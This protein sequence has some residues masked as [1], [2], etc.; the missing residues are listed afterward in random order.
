MTTSPIQS[1]DLFVIERD[2]VVYK[3]SAEDLG[4]LV[5]KE[6]TPTVDEITFTPPVPG[7]GTEVDPFVLTPINVVFGTTGYSLETITF[8]SQKEGNFVA[9]T[10][11]NSVS[12]G[13]RFD[14]PSGTI[15]SDGTYTTNFQFVDAPANESRTTYTG[16]ININTTDIYI[17]WEVTVTPAEASPDINTVVVTE[18]TPGGSRFEDQTF[19]TSISMTNDGEPVSNKY[20]SYKV[21]G[22]IYVDAETSVII[23]VST[24]GAEVGLTF[25]DDKDLSLFKAGDQVVQDSGGTPVTSTISNVSLDGGWNYATSYSDDLARNNRWYGVVFGSN[26]YVAVGDRTTASASPYRAMYSSNGTSWT[27]STSLDTSTT[28]YGVG[29]G[30]S[31]FV[32]VGNS[33]K[34]AYSSNGSSWTMSDSSSLGSYIWFDVTYGGNK[35]VACGGSSNAGSM[36]SSNGINWTLQSISGTDVSWRGIAYGG[37]RYVAVG[38]KSGSS[39]FAAWS[40]SAT[41][42]N[43]VADSSGSLQGS[44]QSIAYG[45]NKF[46]AVCR[47]SSGFNFMYST[48]G[49]SWT[50]SNLLNES[51]SVLSYDWTSVTFDGQKF[52]AVG[53]ENVTASSTDGINWTTAPLPSNSKGY[54]TYSAV[55]YG[56]GKFVA[57][58]ENQNYNLSTDNPAIIYS[59]NGMSA[60]T[61]LTFSNRTNLD[62]FRLNDEVTSSPAGA[63][64][65]ISAFGGTSLTLTSTTGTWSNGKAVTGPT[66]PAATGTVNSVN[67]GSKSINLVSVTSRF[68]ETES[69]YDSDKKLNKTVGTTRTDDNAT[70][71]L[72]TNNSRQVTG[73]SSAPTYYST[74]STTDSVSFTLPTSS[75]LTWDQEFLAGA[76]IQASVYAQNP[77]GR[78]PESGTR[79]SN[80][81]Q[82]GGTRSIPDSMTE[83]ELESQK[84]LFTTRAYRMEKY[85]QDCIACVD[86]IRASLLA[87]GY[88]REEVNSVLIAEAPIAVD[89]Y[90]PLYTTEASAVAAGDGSFHIHE[91][92]GVNYYMPDNGVTIYHGDY[93][94]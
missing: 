15:T 80:V 7:T 87:E 52:V 25:A 13:Q 51:G 6:I 12:N 35:Y 11:V 37:G 46:V 88:S 19:T 92:N 66:F 18:D 32:A 10:D 58:G 27:G 26:K 65:T 39:I 86:D 22:N 83:A 62:N 54:D 43:T 28:W 55:T 45:N 72:D 38:Y 2:N 78:N 74:Q 81:V 91:A 93:V 9:F 82:P 24:S 56:N 4:N 23:A 57:V 3:V 17:S 8:D 79:L 90:Y 89:G 34:S 60:D 49:S 71:W 73:T 53:I 47:S 84:L 42:W 70:V 69:T 44:W 29:Y 76:T 75:G 16:K 77:I 63:T 59:T 33:G 61:V 94:G 68:L 41:S 20:Y 5:P 50:G 1:T 48:N 21:Q 14:Q 67:L 30:G 85:M 40:T 64:G 36:Y 31:R